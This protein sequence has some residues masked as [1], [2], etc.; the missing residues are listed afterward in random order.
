MHKTRNDLSEKVR[1]KV[2]NHLAVRLADA[3]DLGLQCKQAH[4][5]VKGPQFVALHQLF[6]AIANVVSAHV[7]ELAERVTA[8]GGTAEGTAQ[9]VA[10]RTSLDTYPLAITSGPEHLQAL[11]GALGSY[12]R[13]AREAIDAADGLGDMVTADL[14]TEIAGAADKQLWLIEAHLQ[15][16]A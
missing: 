3:I 12:A 5:N 16:D 9:V 14:F 4:W 11:A 10:K 7:D 8:L 15:A 6:D 2:I 13:L 1:R